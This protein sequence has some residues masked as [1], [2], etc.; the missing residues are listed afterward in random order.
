M[1]KQHRFAP[2][3]AELVT[4]SRPELLN[5][6]T[7]SDFRALVHA[8]RVLARRTIAIHDGFGALAGIS[9]V[10]YEIMMLVS[11]LE[12]ETGMTVTELSEM[13][14]QSGAFTT[15]EAGKLVQKGLMVLKKS[16]SDSG[17][18]YRKRVF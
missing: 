10:Q 11:R 7:D 16:T 2:V 15:I 14:L 12:G 9:G 5:N 8:L 3:N 18:G 6:K 4:V 1:S 13:M 17:S